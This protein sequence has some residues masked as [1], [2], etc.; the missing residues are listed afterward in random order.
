MSGTGHLATASTLA[1]SGLISPAETIKP[2]NETDLAWN[3]LLRLDKKLVLQQPLE[4]L[5]HVL[6]VYLKGRRKDENI[7]EVHEDKPVNHVSQHAIDHAL[8]DSRGVGKPERKDQVFIVSRGGIEGC[9]PLIAL[10]NADKMI[11]VAEV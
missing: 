8:E 4:D 6:S 7:I 10:A 5:A 9:L 3:S 2:R 11:G 1:G